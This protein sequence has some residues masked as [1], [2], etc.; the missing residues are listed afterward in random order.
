MLGKKRG[1]RK[2]DLDGV[3]AEIG[4]RET[5]RNVGQRIRTRVTVAGLG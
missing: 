5:Q 4:P 2:N 3:G 1:N